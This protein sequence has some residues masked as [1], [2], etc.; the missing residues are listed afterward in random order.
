MPVAGVLGDVAIHEVVAEEPLTLA[1]V[2]QQVLDQ[3]AGTD[4][5]YPV[6]HPARRRQLAHPGVHDRKAGLA[7]APAL[8]AVRVVAPGDVVV[9]RLERDIGQV[10]SLGEGVSPPVPP[11]QLTNERGTTLRLGTH[12]IEQRSRRD[13]AELEV[14]RQIRGTRDAGKIAGAG[15]VVDALEP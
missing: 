3:E 15:V 5:P 13:R 4:H 2:D 10:W 6:V 7:L 9:A 1:P 8:E 11:R 12:D 14:G